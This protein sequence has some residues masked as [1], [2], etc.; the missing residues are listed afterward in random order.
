[1]FGSTLDIERAFENACAMTRTRVRRRRVGSAVAV[2][3]VF[4][5]VAA[6]GARALGQEDPIP[7]SRTKPGTYVVQPGDSLWWIAVDVGRGRDPRIVVEAIAR[8]N[9]LE[10]GGIVPGQLLVLP[11]RA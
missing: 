7:D 6:Q 3:V 1:M 2:T 10:D 11:A 5:A 4:M 8:M 9:R